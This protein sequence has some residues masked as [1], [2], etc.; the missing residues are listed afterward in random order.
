MDSI[1][2]QSAFVSTLQV[3]KSQNQEQNVKQYK[4]IETDSDL[5]ALQN[6]NSTQN[7]QV[8]TE[9]SFLDREYNYKKKGR[10]E[11]VRE[12]NS[13]FSYKKGLSF[14]EN[15]NLFSKKNS[16]YRSPLPNEN[17]SEENYYINQN[18][19][20]KLPIDDNDEVYKNKVNEIKNIF[21]TNKESLPIFESHKFSTVVNHKTKTHSYQKEASPETDPYIS[22]DKHF[23]SKYK[24][25]FEDDVSTKIVYKRRFTCS[26]K[27]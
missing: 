2:S 1:L 26:S 15:R 6:E 4:Q 21:D 20:D 18:N 9:N 17:N 12:T 8:K 25:I 27:K 11:T 16:L 23:F 5:S 19:T 10:L 14:E 24:F 13:E 22:S 3:S 7:T